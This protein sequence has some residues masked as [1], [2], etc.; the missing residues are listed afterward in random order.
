ML[1]ANIMVFIKKIKDQPALASF[2]LV[3]SLFATFWS[4]FES[5][6]ETN[7]DVAMSMVAHGYGLAEYGSPHLVFSNV[8]WGHMVRSIP[9]INGI[10]GYSLATM[11]V[12]LVTGWSIYYFLLRLGT[13]YLLGALAVVLVFSRPLLFPQFTI[14]AGLLTVAAIIGL[15]VYARFN[16]VGSLVAACILAFF[17]YLVRSH[18]FVLV[19]GVAL[20]FLPWRLLYEQCQV[21]IAFLVLGVTI[22]LA[23]FYN[24]GS[25]SGAEWSYFKEL[26]TARLPYTDYG[27]ARQLEQHREI[28][29]RYG[30]SRNDIELIGK[31]FFVDAN[32]ADTKS[33]N[34]MMSEL[35]P[36]Q[37]Q[38]GSIKS[39][40][41]SVSTALMSIKL[42]PIIL[43]ALLLFVRVPRL[44][45]ALSW[46]FCLAALFSMGFM[47]RPGILRVYL[48]LFSMLFL[49]PMAMWQ[50]N[51]VAQRW[52][53]VLILFVA[54]IG[55]TCLLIP[56][57]LA[58]K[59]A[60]VQVK[61]DIHGLPA[62]PI[63]SWGS[64]FPFQYAFPV[65]TNKLKNHEIRLYGLGVFTRAPFSVATAE[66]GKGL[67]FIR[68]LCTSEGITIMASQADLQALRCYCVEH[69]LGEL[70]VLDLYTTS[71]I[72]VQQ[73]QCERGM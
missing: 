44:S 35:G 72:K 30:Y 37:N 62:G 50:V 51:G 9:S 26:N 14:N 52:K 45:V 13:G 33:L 59:Q 20:S 65:L 16:T 66:E 34:A 57:V 6:W 22:G 23:S 21:R 18:E 2:L 63:V 24:S 25:Y 11:M 19:I 48:P 61:R 12:L 10:W 68:R 4:V 60:T 67:G 55:N 41:T 7:D 56:G 70:R 73:V 71:S 5:H 58:A 39:G 69:V 1:V 27:A 53:T 17:G 47:G 64:A 36:R 49:L 15:Q 40:F 32:I 8:L 43:S 28:I 54:C 42:L 3:A 46:V 29:T 31:W 38:K